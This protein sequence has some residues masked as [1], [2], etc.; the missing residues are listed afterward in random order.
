M[1]LFSDK[2][3]LRKLISL[4]FSFA[5]M[6]GIIL[7]CTAILSRVTILSPSYLTAQ[8][9]RSGYLVSVEEKIESDFISYGMSSGFDEEFFQNSGI[10]ENIKE[11]VHSEIGKMFA[12]LASGPDYAQLHDDLYNKLVSHIEQQEVQITEEIDEAVKYL[13]ELFQTAYAKEISFPLAGILGGLIESARMI[14]V[15]FIILGIALI[16]MPIVVIAKLNPGSRGKSTFPYWFY[17]LSGAALFFA[18]LSA[19]ISISGMI[20]R[21]V[22]LDKGFYTFV[23]MYANGILELMMLFAAILGLIAAVLSINY[24]RKLRADV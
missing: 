12:P 5:L 14:M 15:V 8:M 18:F 21:I 24:R 9:E 17:P 4:L 16:I 11:D 3:F 22:I 1:L 23:T 2:V 19:L 13:V 20:E 10:Y 7:I 6:I